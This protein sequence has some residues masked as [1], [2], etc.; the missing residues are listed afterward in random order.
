[1]KTTIKSLSILAVA[2]VVPFGAFAADYYDDLYTAATGYVTMTNED[3]S[4][5]RSFR[6]AGYWSDGREPHSDT[7]YYVGSKVRLYTPGGDATAYSFGGRRLVVR[8]YVTHNAL[9]ADTISWTEVELLPGSSYV[10]GSVGNITAGDFT[11]SGTAESPSVFSISRASGTFTIVQAMNMSSGESGYVE[12]RQRGAASQT[13]RYTGDWTK[14]YGTLVMPT[15]LT[16]QVKNGFD[17]PGTF[18]TLPAGMSTLSQQNSSYTMTFGKMVVPSGGNLAVSSSSGLTVGDLE[19]GGGGKI[20]FSSVGSGFIVN[21][22]NKLSLAA[23]STVGSPATFNCAQLAAQTSLVFRL[24]PQAAAAGVADL[25][26]VSFTYG[27]SNYAGDLPHVYAFEKDDPAVAGGKYV[28]LSMKPVVRMTNQC[29]TAKSALDVEYNHPEQ[30]WSNGRW[31]E[32]GFDYL[33]VQQ[34]LITKCG[35][36]PYVFPGDSMALRSCPLCFTRNPSDLTFGDLI[37]GGACR[38]RMID[39]MTSYVLRGKLTLS[40]DTDGTKGVV[41]IPIANDTSLTIASEIYGDNS[42][43]AP[44]EVA[45]GNLTYLWG[46]LALTGMNTN[47]TGKLSVSTTNDTYTIGGVSY[48]VSAASNVTLRVND[49]RNLGGP[50]AAFAYDSLAIS[51]N[52]RLAVDASTTFDEPTRGWYFP[53]NVFLSVAEDATATCK[54]TITLGGGIVKEG[55]G[56][57]CLASK[58]VLENGGATITVEEGTLA[59]GKSDALKNIDVS[60]AA[61]TTFAVDVASSDAAMRT[62][63]VDLTSSTVTKADAELKLSLLGLPEVPDAAGCGPYAVCTYNEDEEISCKVKRTWPGFNM[64]ASFEE[65]DNGD[66]TKTLTVKFA[67]TGIMLIVM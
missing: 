5:V 18:K 62:K 19:V 12:V 7:N 28:G 51:N 16:I 40:T 15:N 13:F 47:W 52:C 6:T 53:R 10:F 58:P 26:A 60:F 46:T 34:F 67:P 63:G 22:T 24:S 43:K 55:A 35:S 37:L 49:A 1:M 25:D 14:F 36:N 29:L 8:N 45:N 27:K 50:L 31:P 4:A 42:I 11:I 33:A 56:T 65:V 30:Y 44:L 39:W 57:L 23:G 59:V 61:G 2:F 9:L 54:N 21:V 66:G 32:R 64:K 38:V 17:T 20:G 3:S 41:T 48:A